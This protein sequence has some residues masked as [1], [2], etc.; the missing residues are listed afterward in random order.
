MEIWRMLVAVP[1]LLVTS[2][3]LAAAP[4][5]PFAAPNWVKIGTDEDGFS[6]EIDKESIKRESDGLVGFIDY[7]EAK[8]RG[9]AVDCQ[10]RMMYP[11]AYNDA[12]IYNPDWRN[13]G[14]AVAPNSIAELELQY[15]CA[16]TP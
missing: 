12:G 3:A 4:N 11:P 9:N 15:V 8:V 16:N 14:Y 6:W 2:Q 10:R 1:A 7:D 5:E 13:Q